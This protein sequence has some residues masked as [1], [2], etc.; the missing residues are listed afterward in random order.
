MAETLPPITTSSLKSGGQL[1][2]VHS[3]QSAILELARVAI[4]HGYGDHGG[5]Y[6]DLMLALSAAGISAHVV[7]LRGQGRS[8][9]PR[10][11]VDHWD[12]YL[13]DFE[14]LLLSDTFRRPDQPPTPAFL[15]GHSHGGLIAAVATV[16]KRWTTLCPFQGVILS[17]PYF[18]PAFVI[19]PWKLALGRLANLLAPSIRISTGLAGMRM[20]RDP[21][22]LEEN[23]TD[24]LITRVA[25]PRW[26][27]GATAAQARLLADAGQFDAPLL[28]L[29]GTEDPV[30]DPAT[31][32]LFFARAASPD[33][34]KLEY[35]G[36][37][38]ELLR[39]IERPLIFAEI[40]S[41]I[42]KRL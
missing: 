3:C 34:A 36:L 21:E 26:Y 7:D 2:H 23:R 38:H 28:M 17:S 25:T 6:R 29:L 14:A 35:P 20:C 41:W 39:E 10:G 37:L 4:V 5:R 13:N 9:G 32:R 30:A 11:Y 18:A 12:D 31:M 42:K 22:K 27:V 1:L 8:T 40:I 24:P 16:R 19:A 33:R 15:L